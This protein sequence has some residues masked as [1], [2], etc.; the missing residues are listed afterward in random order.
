MEKTDMIDKKEY[1]YLG[2]YTPRKD[3]RDIVTGKCVYL[4]DHK[5][6]NLLYGRVF[7]S[8]YAHAMIKKIDI[9]KAEAVPGVAAV[10]TYEN[11]PEWSKEFR[12]GTP[13]VKP[14]LS[15]HLRM[16]GDPVAIIAAESE[17]IC[18]QAMRLIEVEY[19]QLPAVFD[20][21]KAMEPGAPQIYPEYFESN[22]W[23]KELG[24]GDERMLGSVE[25]GDVDKEF[26]E[27]D[28]IGGGIC[29]FETRTVPLAPEPPICVMEYDERT[30]MYHEW[31]TAQGCH[32]PGMPPDVGRMPHDIVIQVKTF[33]VG[34]S[35][36]NKQELTAQTEYLCM[37]SRLTHRPV[38]FAY[39]KEDQFT[40]F[41][42]RIGSKMDIEFAMKDGIVTAVRGN[43]Y[44]DAGT[45]DD[46]SYCITAVGLGEMQLALAKCKAWDVDTVMAITNRAYSGTVRGFGGQELK[47]AMMPLVAEAM[48]KADIDPIQFFKD[49]F[50]CAGDRYMWRD[51]IWYTCH[52]VDYRKTIDDAAASFGWKDKWK[53]WMK[54]TRVNGSKRVGVGASI[55]GNGD[56]GEDNS[57]ALVQLRM[58]GHVVIMCCAVESG[59]GQRMAIEKM[60]AEVL[61]VD[62][63]KVQVTPPSDWDN[64]EDFGLCGS[65]GTLTMGTAVT[66]AAEDAKRQL[67]ELAAEKLCISPEQ[68]RTED[69]YLFP[70]NKPE[71]KIPWAAVIP[72]TTDIIGKGNWKARYNAPNCVINL[73]EVEVD[74]DTGEAKL[75]NMTI[76]TDVGQVID[77]KA[78]EMQLQVGIGSAAIDTGLFEENILDEYTGRFVSSNLI[79]YKW[80]P[81]NDFPPLDLVI[82]ESQPNISRFRAVGVGE[83]SGA[84]GAAAIQMA[85]QNAIG[86][87][88]RTYP[89]TPD[90]ILKA[91]GKG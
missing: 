67:F 32:Q 15:K 54:P 20:P 31:A 47:S 66:R 8:P 43:W 45:V 16:V 65:R 55:H 76:G 62:V 39:N 58:K 49:N 7:G 77:S 83:I 84:A 10:V 34:G 78:C 22:R 24:F 5:F 82:N 73:A 53:G 29:G 88:Y 3:A 28:F 36:G 69:G 87:E 1:R 12:Q 68:V 42:F 72:Y 6:D 19:E 59:Q 79:D 74:V 23:P 2:K 26:A 27:A 35:Y 75:L 13:A 61:N 21:M 63:N 57:E 9:S 25:R 14:L 70:Y 51:C 38:K 44:A 48:R 41:E 71:N 85:V 80:R 4:E 89:A 18:R 52:E 17:D 40:L 33:N 30:G 81:F 60:V 37:L 11:Q 50:V 56:V 90:N 46:A 64:P 86:V 91:L